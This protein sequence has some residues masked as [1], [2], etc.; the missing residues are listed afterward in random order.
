[1]TMAIMVTANAAAPADGRRLQAIPAIANE[2]A[3]DINR[4]NAYVVFT[5]CSHSLTKFPNHNQTFR[6]CT[7]A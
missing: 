5:I 2:T 7:K 1:M 3:P 6:D 4:N